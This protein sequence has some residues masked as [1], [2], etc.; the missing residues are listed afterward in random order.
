[1]KKNSTSTARCL[2]EILESSI[3]LRKLCL[4]SF[5]LLVLHASAA[6]PMGEK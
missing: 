4:E 3:R 5:T 6:C 1:M 2:P